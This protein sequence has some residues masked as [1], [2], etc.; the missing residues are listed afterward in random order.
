MRIIIN[1]TI[2]LRQFDKNTPELNHYV[3]KMLHRIA[4]DCKMPAMMYQ[5]SI[6]RVFQKVFR[7]ENNAHKVSFLFTF[8]IQKS[9]YFHP[10]LRSMS[11]LTDEIKHE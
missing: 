7:S 1:L 5:A 4:V 9:Y 6:F 10:S 2:L 11:T 8:L 3:L